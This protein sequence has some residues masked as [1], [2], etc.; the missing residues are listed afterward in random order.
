VSGPPPDPDA[1]SPREPD[2]TPPPGPDASPPSEP[3]ETTPGATG[4]VEL[5]VANGPLAAPV[6]NRVVSMVLAGTA[7]PLDRLD[8][9]LIL[10][11]A[12]SAHAPA[13]ALDSHISFTLTADTDA[14]ELR[15]GELRTGGASG[16]I[17]DAQLP[18]VGNVIERF[19]DSRR[20]ELPEDGA[21]E[22]LVLTLGFG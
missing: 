3:D 11:D 19:S 17:D 10:C 12:V 21:G 4:P 15:V 9:A 1:S 18:D 13:Y 2:P 16:L 5:R 8:D 14:I 6:L 20:V 7:C 22:E